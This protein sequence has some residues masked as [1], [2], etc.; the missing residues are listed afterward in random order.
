MT[1]SPFPGG[2]GSGDAPEAASEYAPSSGRIR[3]PDPT[4]G[5][6]ADAQRE[7]E[8][9]PEQRP[10]HHHRR[11]EQEE[12]VQRRPRRVRV[13]LADPKQRVTAMRP[14]VELEQQTS[15]GEALISDLVRRQLKI[16]LTAACVVLVVLGAL[17]LAFFFSPTFADLTVIGVPVP[18]LLLGVLPFPLLFAAGLWYNRKAERHEHD[19]VDMFER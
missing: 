13:V 4:L 8:F 10:R 15:W 2:P 12:P 7:P 16:G 5:R 18:W 14:K 3:R 17:P 9:E 6:G 19:F 1:Q 11:W